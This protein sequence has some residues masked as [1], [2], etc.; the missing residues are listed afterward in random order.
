MAYSYENSRGQTYYL[1]ARDVTLRNGTNQRIYFFAKEAKEGAIDEIP[2][3]R[4]VKESSRTGLPVLASIGK[5]E[6]DAAAAKAKAD[7]AG[8]AGG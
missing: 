2:A 1:H 3:G 5:A 4:E 7:K 8:K 6:K